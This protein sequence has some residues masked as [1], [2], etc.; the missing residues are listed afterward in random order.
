MS[1]EEETKELLREIR[2]VLSQ[3]E[4]Q[5]QQYLQEIRKEY[6]SYLQKNKMNSQH[7]GALTLWLFAVMTV[8]N[9]AAGFLLKGASLFEFTNVTA[10]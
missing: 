5:Y 4:E 7:I 8:A 6:D 3:R 2:D 9:L 10:M 1:H